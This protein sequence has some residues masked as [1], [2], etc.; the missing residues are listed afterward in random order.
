M[1]EEEYR[2]GDV[3]KTVFEVSDVLRESAVDEVHRSGDEFKTV[4]EL[5]YGR[6]EW[7]LY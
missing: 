7:A 1:V 2:L 4:F 6:R 3:F 5:S